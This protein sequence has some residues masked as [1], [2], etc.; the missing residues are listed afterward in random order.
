VNKSVEFYGKTLVLIKIHG[1]DKNWAE[2][3]VGEK[4]LYLF[5]QKIA[6]GKTGTGGAVMFMVSNIG[7]TTQWLNERGVKVEAAMD[8]P[9]G[10]HAARFNDPDGN[11]IGIF[12]PPH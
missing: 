2:F 12:E 11:V 4:R 10:G 9:G 5:D 1:D 6:Q 8:S 3:A 7:R